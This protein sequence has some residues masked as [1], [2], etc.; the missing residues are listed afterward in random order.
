MGRRRESLGAAT[1]GPIGK[2]AETLPQ[3]ASPAEAY[4]FA[5]FV[6]TGASHATTRDRGF[7]S[8]F[9]CCYFA[10]SRRRFRDAR[11]EVAANA[12]TDTPNRAIREP[13]AFAFRFDHSLVRVTHRSRVPIAIVLPYTL[14]ARTSV[15]GV[16]FVAYLAWAFIPDDALESLGVYYYPDKYWALAVPV[17]LFALGLYAAWAYEGV[18]LLSVRAE[19]DEDL[20]AEVGGSIP[21][22]KP[23]DAREETDADP[24]GSVPSIHDVPLEEVSRVLYRTPGGAQRVRKRR[25]A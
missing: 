2:R 19:D 13:R 4:G 3:G 23:T 1:A 6:L 16:S 24:P 7:R 18:N 17:W 8:H 9:S 20:I 15:A 12:A 21:V 5:G 25:V 14:R 10:V 22:R 11:R